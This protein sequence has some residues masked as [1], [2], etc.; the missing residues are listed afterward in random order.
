MC[1]LF[2]ICHDFNPS[3]WHTQRMTNFVT[4]FLWRFFAPVWHS[5]NTNRVKIIF[6]RSNSV[7]EFRHRKLQK[8]CKIVNLLDKI[9]ENRERLD[10]ECMLLGR[11]R[12]HPI[13]TI[14]ER[15]VVL[16]MAAICLSSES[17]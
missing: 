13:K 17:R 5:L 16:C 14:R 12:F 3:V 6:S 1:H 9:V 8:N 15:P 7:V 2:I 10:V 11:C 4:I